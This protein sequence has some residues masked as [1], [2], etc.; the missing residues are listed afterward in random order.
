MKNITLKVSGMSCGHCVNSIET[1]LKEKNVTAKVDLK[2]K[3]VNAQF[4]ENK[5]KE[6]EIKSVLSELGFQA[7]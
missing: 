4:D 2:K 3:T 1:S 6:A 5:I 7:E